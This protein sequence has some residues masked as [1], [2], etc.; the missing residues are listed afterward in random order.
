MCLLPTQQAVPSQA[1][2]APTFTTPC[3][4]LG[5]EQGP[6]YQA[7]RCYRGCPEG[8]VASGGGTASSRPH[9]LQPGR[10]WLAGWRPEGRLDAWPSEG[11]S[12]LG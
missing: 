3:W 6:Q 8:T 10:G 1:P 2:R 11:F 7:A 5:W 4:S 12:A 9:S